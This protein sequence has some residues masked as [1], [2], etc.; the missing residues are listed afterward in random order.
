[1]VVV[2][3]SIHAHSAPGNTLTHLYTFPPYPCQGSIFVFAIPKIVPG[4]CLTPFS[5]NPPF[6]APQVDC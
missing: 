2:T 4:K 6:F 3:A 1:V 5:S